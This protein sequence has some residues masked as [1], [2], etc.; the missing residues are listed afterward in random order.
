MPAPAA[1]SCQA[2]RSQNPASATEWLRAR[3]RFERRAGRRGGA[4]NEVAASPVQDNKTRADAGGPK[5]MSADDDDEEGEGG[6]GAASKPQINR[7]RRARGSAQSHSEIS[8]APR[9]SFRSARILTASTVLLIGALIG[10]CCALSNDQPIARHRTEPTKLKTSA[11]PTQAALEAARA[12]AAH[13]E[14]PNRLGPARASSSVAKREL[15][16]DEAVQ[17]RRPQ[18]KSRTACVSIPFSRRF[19]RIRAA[20]RRSERS[21]EFQH[22]IA[23]D[24]LCCQMFPSLSDR[25]GPS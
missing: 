2:Y 6:R 19:A 21:F 20:R 13:V 12:Q 3:G 4:E 8:T 16:L 15:Q 18:G 10:T 17:R 24:H 5:S 14:E 7:P 22:A 11:K 25:C 23:Q 9:G 1:P